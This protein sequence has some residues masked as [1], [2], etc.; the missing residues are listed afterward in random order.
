MGFNGEVSAVND[1]L[2]NFDFED[3]QSIIIKIQDNL[4]QGAGVK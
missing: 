1:C 2:A 3:A 4:K